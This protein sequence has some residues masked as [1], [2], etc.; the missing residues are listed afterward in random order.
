M[1]AL[2]N[3]NKRRCKGK[4]HIIENE[5]A[6][7]RRVNHPNIILLVE[8]FDTKDSLYLV[9]EYVKG[10]DLFDDIAL[11]TKYT[12]RDASSMINN[13][14]HALKYLHN[15]RIVHRDV[16]PENLLVI[17]HSDGSKSLK[18]GDFGL[19]TY[20]EDQLF[21]VCGTPTYVAP[22]ILSEVGYDFK[23]DIWAAGVILYILLCGFPPFASPSNDQ[24]ELFDQI[25]EG[26]YEFTS[27]YWD[28]VSESAMELISDMLVVDPA[29]RLS[30]VDIL[31][32]PWVTA[33]TVK[34]E[35]LSVGEN[36][37][38]FSRRDKPSRSR[39]GIRLVASTPLDHPSRYFQGR[40]AGLTVPSKQQT[41]T[42][43]EDEDEIF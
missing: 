21:T 14:V 1:Y 3:I 7:L 38:H 34:D 12:E 6:I 24:E 10:G 42:E 17:D 33:E 27:P 29:D 31:G 9:M 8:E 26:R 5:V 40:R 32:H 41:S 20:C 36:I 19:A 37:R 30:A 35:E 2:K 18:L 39:A 4:E 22:E 13:L 23:V 25:A 15:L 28:D 16:K 11:S 43:G